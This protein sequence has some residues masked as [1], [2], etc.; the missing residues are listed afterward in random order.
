MTQIVGCI[1][2]KSKFIITQW[3]SQKLVM[4]PMKCLPINKRTISY[5]LVSKKGIHR[6]KN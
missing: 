4:M 6:I 5:Q 2:Q 1:M 3:Q